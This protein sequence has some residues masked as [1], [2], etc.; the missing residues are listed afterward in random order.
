MPADRV[1]RFGV[2]TVRRTIVEMWDG[3]G[4]VVGKPSVG[5]W[6][7]RH[8]EGTPFDCQCEQSYT[9]E[10]LECCESSMRMCVLNEANIK[11][12]ICYA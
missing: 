8:P 4:P 7:L 10:V 9:A 11:L 12:K 1:C 5:L 3:L 2:K 6:L